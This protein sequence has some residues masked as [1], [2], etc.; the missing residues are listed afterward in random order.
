ML[1]NISN[2][3]KALNKAEQKSIEGGIRDFQ[4]CQ[5]NSDCGDSQYDFCTSTGKC[6]YCPPHNNE[7]VCGHILF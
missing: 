6:A 4:G 7:A 3:G 5:T 2:L 1:K